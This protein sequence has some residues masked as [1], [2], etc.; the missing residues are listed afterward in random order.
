[1]CGIPLL[2][3]ISETVSVFLTFLTNP[4]LSLENTL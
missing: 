4:F 2:S 1:M 3:V